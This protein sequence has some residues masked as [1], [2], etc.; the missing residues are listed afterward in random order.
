MSG[1]GRVL[2]SSTSVNHTRKRGGAGNQ[3]RESGLDEPTNKRIS[4]TGSQGQLYSW[5]L[6]A[7]SQLI[8]SLFPCGFSISCNTPNVCGS[9]PNDISC[10]H[11]EDYL[12]ARHKWFCNILCFYWW[13]YRRLYSWYAIQLW[14]H[15]ICVWGMAFYF[16]FDGLQIMFFSFLS[17][18]YKVGCSVCC[19][20]LLPVGWSRGREL[21]PERPDYL[22]KWPEALP[23]VRA[24]SPRHWTMVSFS[25]LSAC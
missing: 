18:Y 20:A 23:A 25:L 7:C 15:E 11:Q 21:Y 1:A 9:S 8:S 12:R 13:S 14:R 16:I 19:Q 22:A 3:P 24:Q 5:A 6:S 17:V 10:F 4:L 2:S